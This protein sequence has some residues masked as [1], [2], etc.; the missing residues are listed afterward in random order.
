MVKD[1]EEKKEEKQDPMEVFV[2]LLA[3]DDTILGT[4]DDISLF[5]RLNQL[6]TKL[7]DKEAF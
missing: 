6:L 5:C 2:K 1:V 3:K 4:H 7:Q